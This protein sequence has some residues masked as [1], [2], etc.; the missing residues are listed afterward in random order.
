MTRLDSFNIFKSPA[1]P[2]KAVGRIYK[3][4]PKL[5]AN[6]ATGSIANLNLFVK[7]SNFSLDVMV[8]SVMSSTVPSASPKVAANSSTS[9]VP[10][11]I[12]TLILC[13]PSAPNSSV[14]IFKASV[15][16]AT[17]LIAT[18]ATLRLSVISSVPDDAILLIDAFNPGI[19]L[20]TEMPAPSNCPIRA[21]VSFIPRPRFLKTGPNSVVLAVN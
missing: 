19:T 17:S 13:A 3:S 20:E 2:A 21:I 16:L 10:S 12:A 18:I 15:S 8:D 6:P 11:L 14:A 4:G 1:I 9:T 7:M 5:L